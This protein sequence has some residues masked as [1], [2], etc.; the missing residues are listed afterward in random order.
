[1]FGGMKAAML[2]GTAVEEV[3]T[4][5]AP[6]PKRPTSA[7][8]QSAGLTATQRAQF[9][10]DGFVRLPRAFDG[11]DAMADRLWEH[12]ARRGIDRHDAATWPRG[13]AHHLQKLL[14][15]PVFIPIGGPTTSAAI[16]SLLGAGRWTR[17]N[18][19][20]EFL[21]NFP[22]CGRRWTVPTLWH[23]DAAYHDPVSPLH[24]VSVFSFLNRVEH[25]GGGT[26]VLAG[27]HRIIARFAGRH[28]ELRGEKTATV[29]RAFYQSH[30]KLAELVTVGNDD[31]RAEQFS[32]EIDVD[33]LPA[34]VVELTGDPGDVV[35]VHPLLA[36]C[37]SPNCARQ[38]R[39][40][41]VIRPRVRMG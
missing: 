22:E 36:H 30:P 38:P 10:V 2:L 29:R 21:V 8:L 40:M 19:W 31:E 26:L 23:T 17:P 16:D 25:A 15:E 33:G 34:R 13:K 18:H 20:G 14:H 4:S 28:P 41:R 11:A 6:R 3:R 32:A 12:L 7:P 35:I 37:V 27:S 1:M 9:D 24:G 5:V 39:F